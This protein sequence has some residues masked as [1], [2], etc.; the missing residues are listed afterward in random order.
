MIKRALIF[1]AGRGERMRPL[2]DTTPK[3]LLEVGGKRLVEWH[4]RRLA[5]CNVRDIVVNTAHLAEQ[6]PATLGDG[7]RFGVRIRYS[8]EGAQALET[9]G[10]ML[11]ALPLLGDEP[12]LVINGDVWCDFDFAEL[13]DA[14]SGLAHLVMVDRPDYMKDGDFVLH[15]DASLSAGDGDKLVYS[16]IGVYRPEILAN[17]RVVIGDAPGA[18]ATPPRF[19]L[20][21]LLLRAINADRM[22][23]QHHRGNWTDVGTPQRL[24]ELDARL[25]EM[26]DSLA[27]QHD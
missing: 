20:L 14:P 3:P 21:P 11:H 6:F 4:L 19:K 9:G 15:A 22:T 1:A 7:S 27:E 13:P 23:G 18:D 2:T 8:N 12:F 16:G 25:G 5:S 17:W 24:A 26:N 10:G